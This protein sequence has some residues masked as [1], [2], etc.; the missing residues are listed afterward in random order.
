[1]LLPLDSIPGWHGRYSRLNVVAFGLSLYLLFFFQCFFQFS[2]KRK[3]AFYATLFKCPKVCV[4]QV[5]ISVFTLVKLATFFSKRIKKWS[6]VPGP[7]HQN[8]SLLS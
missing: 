2:E 4:T 7:I 3:L 8:N 6:I 1:M 5:N